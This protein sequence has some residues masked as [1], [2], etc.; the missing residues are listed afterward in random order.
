MENPLAEQ[1]MNVTLLM[2][3]IRNIRKT[4]MG[5][6]IV[7]KIFFENQMIMQR[8]ARATPCRP[9]RAITFL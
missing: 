6:G 4:G 3:P 8:W 5:R 7:S 2:Q 1:V 9:R